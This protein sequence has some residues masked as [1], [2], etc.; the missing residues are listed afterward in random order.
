MPDRKL[1]A[2]GCIKYR[3]R[4]R[5]ELTPLRSP[6][7]TYKPLTEPRGDGGDRKTG[8]IGFSDDDDDDG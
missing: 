2:S 3:Q 6:V 8:S 1:R 4:V 5:L 7:L